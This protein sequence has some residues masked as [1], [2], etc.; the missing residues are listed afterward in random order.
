M[1]VQPAG[2][3]EVVELTVGIGVGGGSAEELAQELT[4]ERRDDPSNIRI[5][6]SPSAPVPPDLP[7][8]VHGGLAA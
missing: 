2:H 8:L 1:A 5:T 7:G 3:R 4:V 6:S